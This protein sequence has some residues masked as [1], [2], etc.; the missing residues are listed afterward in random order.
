MLNI[1]SDCCSYFINSRSNK[2]TKIYF[3]FKNFNKILLISIIII[4]YSV[5]VTGIAATLA[6]LIVSIWM[7]CGFLSCPIVIPLLANNSSLFINI[8]FFYIKFLIYALRTFTFSTLFK[9]FAN[10]TKRFVFRFWFLTFS[11]LSLLS[12]HFCPS[13]RWLLFFWFCLF[14]FHLFNPCYSFH[15][16]D[17]KNKNDSAPTS[18]Q[19]KANISK[20]L[21]QQWETEKVIR[22]LKIIKRQNTT[23]LPMNI[24]TA[25][26]T[27]RK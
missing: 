5:S 11:L 18:R 25:V 6:E 19:V 21:F 26:F 24:V 10:R 4:Y 12:P 23:K 9:F 16:F 13:L 17:Y 15:S 2:I 22:T 20:P 3:I 1:F 8:I 27:C 7:G 14:N